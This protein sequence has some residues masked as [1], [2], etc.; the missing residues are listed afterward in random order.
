MSDIIDEHEGTD[1]KSAV[2]KSDEPMSILERNRGKF[3]FVLL[4]H[5]VVEANTKRI[6]QLHDEVIGYLTIGLEKAIQIG[7]LLFEQKKRIRY[8]CFTRWATEY[9]PFT[10]R[11]AQNY[12][13]LYHCKEE[14]EKKKI[15]TISDAYAALKGEATPEE[16]IV[17]NDSIDISSK[18]TIVDTCIDLDNMSLPTKKAKGRMSKLVID[19]E[20]ISRIK[21]EDY[22]FDQES[23]G[24]YVK[25]VVEIRNPYKHDV[26]LLGE[27][28]IAMSSLLKSGGKVIFQKK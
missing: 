23:K 10:I 13:K 20:V 5:D 1:H 8:R 11:T 25:I 3:D 16:I 9:L 14:L 15:T 17:V 24:K 4:E 22:P 21:N 28:F 7:E 19:E 18:P 12:M 27:S 26:E 2:P 6:S